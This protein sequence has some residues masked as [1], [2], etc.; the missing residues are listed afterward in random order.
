VAG[1]ARY[2]EYQ[3]SIAQAP[4]Q[5]YWLDVDPFKLDGLALWGQMLDLLVLICGLGR[6]VG[7]GSG[8]GKTDIFFFVAVFPRTF[9]K[10]EGEGEDDSHNDQLERGCEV[11]DIGTAVDFADHLPGFHHADVVR[12]LTNQDTQ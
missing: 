7:R 9:I 3:A 5:C 10:V 12:Q 6:P 4:S 2:A 8:G 1:R 11:D